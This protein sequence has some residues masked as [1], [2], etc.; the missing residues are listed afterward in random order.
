MTDPVAQRVRRG[1]DPHHPAAFF[2]A[3]LV[4]EVDATLAPADWSAAPTGRKG[5]ANAKYAVALELE[6]YA[7]RR[8]ELS[9]TGAAR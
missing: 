4:A 5:A 6:A 1:I 9:L 2:D 3:W 7:A 8:L